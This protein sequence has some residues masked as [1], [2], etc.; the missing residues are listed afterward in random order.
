MVKNFFQFVLNLRKRYATVS[1]LLA[2]PQIVAVVL[3]VV[4]LPI[5]LNNISHEDYGA[6]QFVLAIQAW[7]I[8]FSATNITTGAKQS[9]VNGF[10]GTLWFACLER[11]KLLAPFA[12]LF[13]LVSFFLN[14]TDYFFVGNLAK[15]SV[16]VSIFLLV[17]FIPSVTYQDYYIA[18]N[19]FYELAIWR[20]ITTI[21]ISVGSALTAWYFKNIFIYLG[22]QLSIT[23]ILGWCGML[24]VGIREKVFV[25]YKLGK[26][27][28]SCYLYGIKLIPSQIIQATASSLSSF[29]VGPF[30]GLVHLAVFSVATKIE[31]LFRNFFTSTFYTIFY[32]DFVNRG[33]AQ[34]KDVIL[35]RMFYIFIVSF[36]LGLIIWLVGFVYIS[37][38]LPKSYNISILYLGILLLGFPAYMMQV[39]LKTLLEAFL[40][41]KE[42][43][44][45][46]IIPNLL[47]IIFVL[48][49]GLSMG[50]IGFCFATTLN[51]WVTFLL[52]YILIFYKEEIKKNNVWLLFNK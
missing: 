29:V 36:C 39:I 18:K 44:V 21:F 52:Y 20:I 14:M 26:V 40:L 43:T 25:A 22:V 34:T 41:H 38:F 6:L 11:I 16:I 13:G 4:T 50:I 42:L 48:W 32:S 8:V 10:D 7:L 19:R 1:F 37:V 12:I 2:M 45:V 31:V 3:G 9:I 30:F 23:A 47:F 49:F 15:L 35:K 27:D 46:A 51:A 24:W 33:H 28:R 5:V 17:G